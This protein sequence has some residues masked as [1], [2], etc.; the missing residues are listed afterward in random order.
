MAGCTH[1]VANQSVLSECVQYEKLEKSECC[2]VHCV[3]C[4]P[5]LNFKVLHFKAKSSKRPPIFNA[6][7][8]ISEDGGDE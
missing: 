7:L 6:T 8:L 5:G 1:C 2:T 3:K 4:N